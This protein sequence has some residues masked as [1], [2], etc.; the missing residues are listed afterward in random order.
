[1][2][3]SVWKGR[4]GGESVGNWPLV[5]FN[6]EIVCDAVRGREGEGERE[7]AGSGLGAV[8]VRFA[9]RGKLGKK[10]EVGERED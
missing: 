6:Q 8:F 1:M 5:D 2:W 9:P 7:I 3:V 10:A 4:G